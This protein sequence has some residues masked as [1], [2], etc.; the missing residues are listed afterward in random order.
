MVMHK[1]LDDTGRAR[2]AA[3]VAEAEATT[4]VELRLVLA[5]YSSHYSAFVLVYPGLLALIAGGVAATITPDLDAWKLFMGEA[6]VFLAAI[7]ALQWLPL[8]LAL[9][10]PSFKREAAWRHARL[11]YASIGLKEPHI[12]SALLIFCSEAERTVEILADDAIG[13]TIPESVWLPVVHAF[14]ADF[15]KGRVADAFV[16]AARDCAAILSPAFPP[17]AGQANEIADDLVEL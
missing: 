7:V 6:V 17:V 10:P 8:R 16:T 15:A 3:A 11:H 14:K 13:E 1:N 9:I 5:H 4:G 2:I 12:K